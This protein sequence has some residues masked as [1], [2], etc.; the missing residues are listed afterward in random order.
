M[1][2]GPCWKPRPAVDEKGSLPETKP[3]EGRTP[4]LAVPSVQNR[5]RQER[6][7]GRLCLASACPGSCRSHGDALYVSAEWG[8][9]AR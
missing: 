1:R 9:Q 3:Q 4:P 2:G 6:D 7:P 5:L 8:A